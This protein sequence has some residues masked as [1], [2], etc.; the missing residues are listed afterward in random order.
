MEIESEW[1]HL[2]LYGRNYLITVQ[3][4]S[5]AF[6]C[7]TRIENIPAQVWRGWWIAVTDEK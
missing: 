5:E 7:T 2:C 6:L 3:N 1:R 4:I